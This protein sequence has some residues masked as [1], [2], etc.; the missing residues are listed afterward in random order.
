MIPAVI[1]S[2]YHFYLMNED[3]QTLSEHIQES[4]ECAG[5]LWELNEYQISALCGIVEDEVQALILKNISDLES[6]APDYTIGK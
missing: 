1:T 6:T 3:L 2:N 4:I 5:S